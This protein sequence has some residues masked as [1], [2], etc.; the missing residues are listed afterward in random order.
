MPSHL[1]SLILAFFLD[2]AK[3]KIACGDKKFD[4]M[5]CMFDRDLENLFKRC[6]EEKERERAWYYFGFKKSGTVTTDK[7]DSNE[8]GK[9]G[10]AK[11][12]N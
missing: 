11:A 9:D 8:G 6:V 7:S 1:L 12:E 10:A 5:F 3:E 4:E 2:Q